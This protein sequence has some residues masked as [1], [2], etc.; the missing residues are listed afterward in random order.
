MGTECFKADIIKCN[1][2]WC[3]CV[4]ACV[5]VCVCVFVCVCDT[6]THTHTQFIYTKLTSSNVALDG[7]CK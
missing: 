6:H 1:F 3:V 7:V 2:G 5:C 4:C